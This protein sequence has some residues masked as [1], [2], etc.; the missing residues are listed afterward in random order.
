MRER[1]PSVVHVTKASGLSGS[2]R[3]LLSLLPALQALGWDVRAVVLEASGGRSF[4]DALQEAGI[5]TTALRAGPNLNPVAVARL[6]AALTTVP[7]DLVH[8]H[9]LHADL[10]G[11]AAARLAGLPGISTVHSAQ[12]FFTKEPYRSAAALAQRSSRA[13]IAI[14][15]HVARC[16]LEARVSVP[17]KLRVVHYG[18]AVEPWRVDV[19]ATAAARRLFAGDDDGRIVIGVASRLVAGKG[20]DVLLRAVGSIKASGVELRLLVAGE[21]PRRGALERQAAAQGLSDDVR[22]LGFVPDMRSFLA[23]CDVVAFPTQPEYGEGFGLAALEA[24][25]AGRPLVATD[26]ASLPEVVGSGEVPLVPPRDVHAMAEALVALAADPGL[27]ARVGR[28]NRRR[29]EERFS[30]DAMADG[31]ARAYA[32]VTATA[33]L[34]RPDVPRGTA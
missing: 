11:Q 9:L 6:R 12:A 21:G 30:L 28:A 14:S 18:I 33:R 17:E 29:V 2:E 3:H 31:T 13:T 1:R 7:T 22:F 16:L 19:A 25:A 15:Q 23:A 24:M 10:H 4:V 27:R 26:V 34:A 5:P 20:H 8:T 32:D